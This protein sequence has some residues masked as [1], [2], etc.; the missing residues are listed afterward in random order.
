MKVIVNR[1]DMGGGQ[2]G[3]LKPLVWHLSTIQ[4]DQAR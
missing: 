1:E 3:T 2:Q 4:A